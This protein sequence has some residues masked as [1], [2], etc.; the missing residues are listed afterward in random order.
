MIAVNVKI[1]GNLDF[2]AKE[3]DALSQKFAEQIVVEARRLI[4]ESVPRGRWY[5]RGAI[6]G[7]RSKAL[8][9]MGLQ[10]RGKTRSV[11]GTRIHR[12]SAKGQPPAKDT[13]RL[14]REIRVARYGKSTWRVVF[15][16][17]YAG[18][19]EFNLDRPVALPAIQAAAE[20][21]FNGH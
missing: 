3:I 21:V 16:A 9:R 4:D 20:K 5:G 10:N 13:G 8:E 14:Y 2:L 19:L 11:T 17:P 12:A 7:R 6:T 15:G 1:I 18:Y